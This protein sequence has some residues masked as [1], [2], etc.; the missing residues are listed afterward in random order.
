MISVA[1][2]IDA[3]ALRIRH[4]FLTLPSLSTSPDACAQLLS[5]SR[6]HATE[7]LDALVGEG[8]LARVADGHYVRHLSIDPTTRQ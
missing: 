6:R 3:D 2:A 5:L 7:I 1:D 4:E 8:F